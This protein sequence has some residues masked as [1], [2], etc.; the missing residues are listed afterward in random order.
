M[1]LIVSPPPG[2]RKATDQAIL[3]ANAAEE[4]SRDLER[5]H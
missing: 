2:M 3:G 1:A 5:E 4:A